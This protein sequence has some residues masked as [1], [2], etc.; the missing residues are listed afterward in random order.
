MSFIDV[1]LPGLSRFRFKGRITNP[2]AGPGPGERD[3]KIE[4]AAVQS[5][6][7]SPNKPS[8]DPPPQPWQ[9]FKS[10]LGRFFDKQK[11]T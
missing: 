4:P 9:Q 1:D 5:S 11:P 2:K 8:D 10:L 7:E 3:T 6:K